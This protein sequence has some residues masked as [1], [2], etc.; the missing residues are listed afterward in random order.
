M[1]LRLVHFYK[2][3]TNPE[4]TISDM[5]TKRDI[6][7]FVRNDEDE[8]VQYRAAGAGAKVF[9]QY[10]SGASW[11]D[12]PTDTYPSGQ[13]NLPVGTASDNSEDPKRNTALWLHP[14]ETHNGKAD[15]VNARDGLIPGHPDSYNYFLR[16]PAGHALAGQAF[17]SGEA[18]PGNAY[19]DP[20][21]PDVQRL[22]YERQN[23]WTWGDDQNPVAWDGVFYDNLDTRMDKQTSAFVPSAQYSTNAA[24]LAALYEFLEAMREEART[25]TGNLGNPGLL[26]ANVQGVDRS[27][28]DLSIWLQIVS[29]LDYVMIEFW[30][31]GK[32]V[33]Q[34]ARQITGAIAAQ[35]EECEVW[36]VAQ[37]DG[38]AA[39]A[40]PDGAEG[41]KLLFALASFLLI[42]NGKA[43]FRA[44]E[45]YDEE[46]NHPIYDEVRES[47]GDPLGAYTLLNG[48]YTRIYSG[49]VVTTNPAT[50]TG[51]IT[52]TEIAESVP[53][54]IEVAVQKPNRTADLRKASKTVEILN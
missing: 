38:A 35:L 16:Y 53:G 15:I 42:D 33:T 24:Y 50:Q 46:Y 32:S 45:T 8:I 41:A 4:F 25:H 30:V 3:T 44:A 54:K 36:C 14:D 9:L 2:P 39:Y 40:N 22:Q 23:T 12:P 10:F 29:R 20:G 17:L 6:Y 5:A 7:C 48:V 1:T 52:F 21:N 27:A 37:V 49:M 19:F 31:L 28:N 34:Y 13:L 11:G 26:G 18:F 51:T 47:G 43:A